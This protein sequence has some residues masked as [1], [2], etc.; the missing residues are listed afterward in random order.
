MDTYSLAHL[1]NDAL[2][3]GHDVLLAQ[4]R[5]TTAAL[6]AHLAE[7]DSRRLYLPA[8]YPSMHSYCLGELHL[9]E[10]AAFRRIRAAR[11]ARRFPVLFTALA[12][13][14]L[15]L[16]A[17]VLLTPHL[18]EENVDEWVAL[19]THQTRARIQ[20]LLA[21]RYPQLDVP[22]SLD[23]IIQLAPAP[24]EG[25]A[26]SQVAPT[27]VGGAGEEADA[28]VAPAPLRAGEMQV[29]PAPVDRPNYA[30]SF[31]P[32]KVAPLAPGRF[33]L[34]VTIGQGT[35]NRLRY[36][37][38]LLGHQI[39]SGDIAR[40]LDLALS[41]LICKLEK[42]KFAATS[43]S[44]RRRRSAEAGTRYVP[45]AV[46]RAVWERDGG[47]CT[48]V[49]AEGR[50]C[51]ARDRLEFDHVD[52]VARGGQASV[53]RMRLRCRA[54]NQYE[55]ELTFGREFMEHK[56]QMAQRERSERRMPAAPATPRAAGEDVIPWLRQLGVRLDE[57]RRAAALC[58]ALPDGSLEERVR[59][60]LSG[61]H[62]RTP[63]RGP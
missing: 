24:V 56:R 21:E 39:P 53:D 16:T 27:P 19:A 7:V 35:R 52:E 60:A 12:E 13:G 59:L 45:A 46:R 26:A 2:L 32:T 28:Q 23:C 50:R 33:A 63:A 14:R 44:R 48:F 43:K 11:T 57:A 17:V 58:A 51:Q 38:R 3:R 18:T 4:E 25:V 15:H 37:Q 34:Q 47:Q 42:Q 36:A 62:P 55:A 1:S 29:A 31:G 8:A 54:H 22:T 40:V 49:S 5:A 6:L 30:G 10:D 41:A 9:S 61:L 20:E